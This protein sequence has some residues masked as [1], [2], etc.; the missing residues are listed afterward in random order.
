MTKLVL[1][2]TLAFSFSAV[3]RFGADIASC[4][5]A[6][7]Q[8]SKLS[9]FPLASGQDEITRQSYNDIRTS[10][11]AAPIPFSLARHSETLILC[12]SYLLDRLMMGHVLLVARSAFCAPFSS[13]LHSR[14]LSPSAAPMK[15]VTRYKDGSRV[16]SS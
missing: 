15:L 3:D 11:T 10:F 4:F 5:A 2:A 13:V 1:N 16:Y 14:G 12:S 6:Q 9:S 8:S 7:V